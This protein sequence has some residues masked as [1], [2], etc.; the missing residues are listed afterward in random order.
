MYEQSHQAN[1]YIKITV[2]KSVFVI[3]G[4]CEC[5]HLRERKRAVITSREKRRRLTE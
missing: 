2:R 1:V 5:A 3:G 4:E